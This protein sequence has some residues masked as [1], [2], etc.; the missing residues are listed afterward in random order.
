MQK[1][2]SGFDSIRSTGS[3]SVC[4]KFAASVFP[5]VVKYM[6]KLFAMSVL[7]VQGTPLDVIQFNVSVAVVFLFFCISLISTGKLGFDPDIWNNKL[8]LSGYVE[9]AYL[10]TVPKVPKNPVAGFSKMAE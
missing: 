6:L 8:K 3:L 7:S 5:T 1:K 9:E 2:L 10:T 4:G